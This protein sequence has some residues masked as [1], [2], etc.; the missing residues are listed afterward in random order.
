LEELWDKRIAR[1]EGREYGGGRERIPHDRYQWPLAIA[2]L[3]M[4]IE[5]SLRERG[6]TAA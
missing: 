3:C 1:M 6:R 2:A 4:A 5:Y